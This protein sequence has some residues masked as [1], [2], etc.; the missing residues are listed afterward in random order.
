MPCAAPRLAPR[1]QARSPG[2]RRWTGGVAPRRGAVS[3]ATTRSNASTR[4]RGSRSEE[5]RVGKEC[6]STCRCRWWT[7]HYKKKREIGSVKRI[8]QSKENGRTYE[9]VHR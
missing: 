2:R 8:T 9:A 4:R 6:G 7:Y 1:R 5:R 3:K